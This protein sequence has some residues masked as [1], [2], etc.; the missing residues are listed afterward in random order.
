MAND[1]NESPSSPKVG[2]P[3]SWLQFLGPL[4]AIPDMNF[5]AFLGLISK[6]LGTVL[7]YMVVRQPSHVRIVQRNHNPSDP[8]SLS[9][10]ISARDQGTV[11]DS[12]AIIGMLGKFKLTAQTFRD[13]YNAYYNLNPPQEKV[14]T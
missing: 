2:S 11:V 4:D 14:G 6:Q 8:E 3:L 10:P 1:Q 7:D 13:A 9:F 12:E 5:Q